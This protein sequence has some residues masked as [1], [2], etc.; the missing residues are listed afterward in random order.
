[1]TETDIFAER[2]EA[3]RPRLRAVAKLGEAAAD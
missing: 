2:F 3:A 1:M